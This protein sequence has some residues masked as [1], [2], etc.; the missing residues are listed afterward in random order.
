MSVRGAQ[1]TAEAAQPR[2]TIATPPFLTG[3]GPGQSRLRLPPDRVLWS[4]GDVADGVYYIESGEIKVAIVSPSGREGVITL[5]GDGEFFGARCL[6]E[7]RRVATVTTLTACSLVRITA[8]KTISMVREE[9]DFAELL[10]RD[11]VLRTMRSDEAVLD[12]LTKTS[13]QRLAQMLLQLAKFRRNS[14]EA[15]IA[16]PVNQAMLAEMIGTT[17]PRVSYFMNK[18]RRQGF[19]KY[20]R[21]GH[22]TVDKS[23]RSAAFES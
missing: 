14:D 11:F 18:F 4:Q 10:V 6:V 19:I 17:R 1:H 12:Q 9:P 23:L 15:L 13:E 7:P 21:Q 5:H 20:N 8:A 3:T 2:R 22:V 16:V